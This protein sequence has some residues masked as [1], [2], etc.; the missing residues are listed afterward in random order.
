MVV[1]FIT[2]IYYPVISLMCTVLIRVLYVARETS[3]VFLEG[4]PDAFLRVI[5]FLSDLL[6]CD[7]R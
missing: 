4:M 6:M 3:E 7:R 1:D 5:S 2:A